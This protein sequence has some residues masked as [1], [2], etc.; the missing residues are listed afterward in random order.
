MKSVG[1]NVNITRTF[2]VVLQLFHFTSQRKNVQGW[3]IRKFYRIRQR[4]F[5]IQKNGV[6]P[7]EISFFVLDQSDDDQI[8][9]KRLDS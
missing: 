9:R 7:F 2:F 8:D 5:E 3:L 4:P 1:E 6:F